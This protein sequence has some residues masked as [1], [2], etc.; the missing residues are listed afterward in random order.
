MTEQHIRTLAAPEPHIL[1]FR[2]EKDYQAKVCSKRV[3][4]TY[5]MVLRASLLMQPR[6]KMTRPNR[7]TY[8][9]ATSSY[10]FILCLF[11]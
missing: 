9:T 11:W 5:S 3:R 2:R 7:T 10:A 6:S 1:L 4:L 8:S